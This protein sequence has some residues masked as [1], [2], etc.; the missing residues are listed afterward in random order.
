M[1]RISPAVRPALPGEEVDLAALAAALFRQG[2]GATHPEPELSRYVTRNFSVETFA[3]DLTDPRVTVLVAE[4]GPTGPLAGY[5][6]LREGPPAEGLTSQESGGRKPIEIGRFY[7]D[8]KW[9]GL[10]VAQ[11]L[12]TECVLEAARRGGDVLW[13]QAWERAAR[14]LAF[15]KKM[16]FV[17]AGNAKFEFGA[18]VD[19]DFLLA[20][21]VAAYET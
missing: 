4:E 18:R 19:N 12:M 8:Q 9:H 10:G 6:I 15:Y 17:V 2:Y 14:A 3:R 5:A 1:Q 16:G 11:A 20:R 13:L 7:V 21:P